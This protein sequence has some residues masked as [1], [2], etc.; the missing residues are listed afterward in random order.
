MRRAPV[1]PDAYTRRSRSGRRSRSRILASNIRK[2][3]S[4]V[5]DFATT[6]AILGE[7]VQRLAHAAGAEPPTHGRVVDR[8]LLEAKA[9]MSAVLPEPARIADAS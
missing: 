5:A 3:D 4:M 8:S 9:M 1:R 6:P 7:I 2:T